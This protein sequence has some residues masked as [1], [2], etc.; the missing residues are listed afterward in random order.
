[1]YKSICRIEDSTIDS[2]ADRNPGNVTGTKVNISCYYT[3]LMYYMYV[4]VRLLCVG[5]TG[6]IAGL[7]RRLLGLG[8]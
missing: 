4:T 3:H 8:E 2:E 7:T 6:R 5:R 1:V